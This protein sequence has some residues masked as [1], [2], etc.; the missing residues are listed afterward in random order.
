MTTIIRSVRAMGF[1]VC[2]IEQPLQVRS[3][4]GLRRLGQLGVPRRG[5][6]KWK[7]RVT[8]S[9]TE[10]LVLGVSKEAICDEQLG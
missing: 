4:Y 6:S 9:A 8:E 2:T 7:S 10:P 3:S 5:I 1:D